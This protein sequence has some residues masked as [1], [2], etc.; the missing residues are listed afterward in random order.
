[1]KTRTVSASSL[2]IVH[3]MKDGEVRSS[4]EGLIPPAETGCYEILMRILR[5]EKK[6]EERDGQRLA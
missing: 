5:R 1:M 3:V 2:R 6:E 4:I